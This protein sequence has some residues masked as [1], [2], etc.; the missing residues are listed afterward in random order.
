VLLPVSRAIPNVSSAGESK[1]VAEGVGALALRRLN[2]GTRA[3][4]LERCEVFVSGQGLAGSAAMAKAGAMHV[5]VLL[6]SLFGNTREVAERLLTGAERPIRQ[7]KLPAYAWPK[8]TGKRSEP[9][10]CLSSEPDPHSQHDFRHEPQ[11]GTD[12]RGEVLVSPRVMAEG[13]GRRSRTV[14]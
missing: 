4:S 6:E 3:P 8:R 12:G 7:P 2:G 9:P 14:A 10:T 13:Q 5:V 11:D 1:K